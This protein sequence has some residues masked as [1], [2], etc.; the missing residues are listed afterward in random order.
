M[1]LSLSMFLSLVHVRTSWMVLLLAQWI[2]GDRSLNLPQRSF[3]PPWNLVVVLVA[4]TEKS[5]E[6]FHLVLPRLL[7]LKALFLLAA[8][9]TC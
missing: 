5:Y 1:P 7:I 3:L 4:L 8:A 6:S 9:A 2:P